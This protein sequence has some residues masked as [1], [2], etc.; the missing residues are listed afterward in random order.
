MGVPGF[1]VFQHIV[2]P[3]WRLQNE[4]SAGCVYVACSV[5]PHGFAEGVGLVETDPGSRTDLLFLISSLQVRFCTPVQ[6]GRLR[7][8][9][10]PSLSLVR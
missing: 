4:I 10:Q 6:H 8:V 9:L 3:I 1:R 5:G 7:S 2:S